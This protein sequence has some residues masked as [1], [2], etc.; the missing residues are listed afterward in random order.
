MKQGQDGTDDDKYTKSAPQTTDSSTTCRILN[1]EESVATG[2]GAETN[3]EG[4]TT[5][6]FL[7]NLLSDAENVAAYERAKDTARNAQRIGT[8]YSV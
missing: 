8:C 2:K 6:M 4:R 7:S 5:A 1:V 3:V